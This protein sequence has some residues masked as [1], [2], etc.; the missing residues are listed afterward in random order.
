MIL[1]GISWDNLLSVKTRQSTFRIEQ[2]SVSCSRR[3]SAVIEFMLKCTI[4]KS[5][6]FKGDPLEKFTFTD[7]GSISE[8]D[9]K[10]VS[11]SLSSF[12]KKISEISSMLTVP[13]N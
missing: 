1:L 2:T 13:I 9:E 5:P 12:S 10:L 11:L 6:S 7:W 4:V 8:I 3:P